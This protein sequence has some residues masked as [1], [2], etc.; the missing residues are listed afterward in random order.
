M[1]GSKPRITDS[2]M[3]GAMGRSQLVSLILGLTVLVGCTGS[4]AEV[5]AIA[6]LSIDVGAAASGEPAAPWHLLGSSRRSRELL[7]LRMLHTCPPQ[8]FPWPQKA[9]WTEIRVLI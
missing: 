2:G 7:L 5:T 8:A 9:S 3:G 1:R 4:P 6:T